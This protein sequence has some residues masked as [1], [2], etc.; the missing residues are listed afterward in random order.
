MRAHDDVVTVERLGTLN[1]A[2]GN[3]TDVLVHFVRDPGCVQ[4]AGRRPQGVVAL[5]VLVLLDL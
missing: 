3:G 2:F 1:D 4:Q 5:L